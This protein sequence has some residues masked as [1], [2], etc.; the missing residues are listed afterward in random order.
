LCQC[1]IDRLGNITLVK[2]SALGR[3]LHEASIVTSCAGLRVWLERKMAA[4]SAHG[5]GRRGNDRLKV[6]GWIP[7][8]VRGT[9]AAG[10]HRSSP[11]SVSTYDLQ[12]SHW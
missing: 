4:K 5:L 10:S 9:T 6:N 11:S 3:S 8:R 1:L 7:D 2:P 12:F